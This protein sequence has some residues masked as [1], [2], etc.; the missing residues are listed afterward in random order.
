[1]SEVL[2]FYDL[3]N[4]KLISEGNALSPAQLHKAVNVKLNTIGAEWNGDRSKPAT[5]ASLFKLYQ[6]R[7]LNHGRGL[8]IHEANALKVWQVVGYNWHN[9][10]A[11]LDYSMIR[12]TR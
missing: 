11:Q 6:F 9:W 8:I 2:T 3:M 7:L 10:P 12:G 5:D 1:M 4:L